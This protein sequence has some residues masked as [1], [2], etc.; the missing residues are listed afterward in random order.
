MND[1]SLNIVATA[2]K[3]R[4]ARDKEQRDKLAGKRNARNN[5]ESF[6]G[7][8]TRFERENRGSI[9]RSETSV[10]RRTK[11]AY[12]MAE[13]RKTRREAGKAFGLSV[14]ETRCGCESRFSFARYVNIVKRYN[15]SLPSW[16]RGF[17]S[18]YSLQKRKR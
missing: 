3:R 6:R 15:T 17:D 4:R 5:A 18:R 16:G 2:L 12:G 14:H 10:R 13:A 1:K 7:R 9:P 8:K 11:R